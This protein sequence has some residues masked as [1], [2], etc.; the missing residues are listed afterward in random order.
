MTPK[1]KTRAKVGQEFSAAMMRLIS[2]T[3]RA[4][5]HAAHFGEWIEC[6]NSH[7]QRDRNFILSMGWKTK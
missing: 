2:A 5:E 6:V 4:H 3:K 7:C 1:R